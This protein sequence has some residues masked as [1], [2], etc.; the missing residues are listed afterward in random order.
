MNLFTYIKERVA[1]LDVAHEYVTL[2]KAGIYYKG[3]CPFHQEKDASFTIS[4]HKGIFYC[5]GCHATGDVISFMAQMEN[6][7]QFEAA[8]LIIEKYQLDIPEELLQEK[9]NLSVSFDAKNRHFGLC[10]L[11]TQ[12][13]SEQLACSSTAQQYLKSRKIDSTIIKKFRIGYFAGGAAKI[14]ALQQF[15]H[16]N[17]FLTKEFIEAHI[18]IERKN[19]HYSPFEDRIIFPI[20]DHLGRQCGFGG[21]IFQPADE[22]AKYYNSS[23]NDFFSKGSLLFGLYQAKKS[24]QS[25]KEA[26]L[27]E[28]YTDCIAMAQYGYTN[29]VA[30]LGTACTHHHLKQ[31]SHYA[32]QLYIIFDGD[33]AGLQAMLRLTQLCWNVN[34]DV[35]VVRLPDNEDP[36]SYL[37]SGKNLKT[38]IEKADDIFS[39]F[40]CHSTSQFKG[41]TLKKKMAIIH[42]LLHIIRNIDDELKKTM[43][44]QD[45]SHKLDIPFETLEKECRQPYAQQMQK[46]T[47]VEIEKKTTGEGE[48]KMFTLLLE[49]PSLLE[50]DGI[51]IMLDMFSE[52]FKTILNKYRSLEKK[53][54]NQL[55]ELLTP[56]EKQ[57][58]N[59][60]IISHAEVQ[61][62]NT[63]QIIEV[64]AKQQWKRLA[65]AIKEKVTKAQQHGDQKQIATLLCQ[66]QELKSKLLNGSI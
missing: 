30:T 12:W 25:T 58:T 31:L 50:R 40:L 48:K 42:E 61:S 26:F 55:N 19:A 8:K 44:L 57:L 41:Q 13:C 62:E 7:H 1:M 22:R 43:L 49:Q 15:A 56:E 23:E 6:C 24:I 51:V 39:F 9:N 20:T 29:T 28:G 10:E 11:V 60:L 21:R 17:N 36:A 65:H 66:L 5:F 46:K 35:R 47:P 45:A 32:E 53:S 38:Y 37:G 64:F 14:K 34:M 54:F 59:A 3:R 18:I 4:P 63:E 52:P 27:V 16:Q 33:S 2:Q